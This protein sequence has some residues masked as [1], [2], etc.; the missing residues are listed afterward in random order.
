MPVQNNRRN[1]AIE[2]VGMWVAGCG[3]NVGGVIWYVAENEMNRAAETR[4]QSAVVSSLAPCPTA[5]VGAD[6]TGKATL[7][8]GTVTRESSGLAR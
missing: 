5:A 1:Y 6:R 8:C 3:G 4:D 7:W 2:K